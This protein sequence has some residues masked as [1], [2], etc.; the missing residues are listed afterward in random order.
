MAKV[1]KANTAYTVILQAYVSSS[2]VKR[3][4]LR[5]IHCV[6]DIEVDF[7]DLPAI[8]INPSH[9]PSSKAI[10]RVAKDLI[11]RELQIQ[12]DITA[13]MPLMK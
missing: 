6:T 11:K 13:L 1:M 9:R 7:G 12:D 3:D 2:W 4:D 5:F 8:P 10:D